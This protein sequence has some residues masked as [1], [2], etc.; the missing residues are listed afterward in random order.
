MN[1]F[2][3]RAARRAPWE[4]A[5]EGAF[6]VGEAGAVGVG[7]RTAE[8]GAEGTA[9]AGTTEAGARGTGAVGRGVGDVRIG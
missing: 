1:T 8:A 9:C 7:A 3:R 6:A 2:L 5:G 4:S